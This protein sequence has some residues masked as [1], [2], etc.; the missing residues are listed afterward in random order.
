MFTGLIQ[1]VGQVTSA[2]CHT[3]GQG[4]PTGMV[5]TVAVDAGQTA[6]GDSFVSDDD[7]LAM[8]ESIT[9]NGVC[10]T[11][12]A[13]PTA[14]AFTVELSPETLAVT[15]LGELNTSALVNLERAMRP[16]DRFGGHIVSGHV[17]TLAQVVDRTDDG[18]CWRFYFRLQ[19]VASARYFIEK[20]SVTID[21]VSLTVNGLARDKGLFDVAII[22]HT[23]AHTTF[24]QLMP[25]MWV[26][27]ECDI[28]GKYAASLLAP[29]APQAD[30]QPLCD[31]PIA[32]AFA[33]ATMGNSNI[34]TG[35][36]FNL[37]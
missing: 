12:V 21:G 18:E 15:T 20:G 24:A 33:P 31:E 5:L 10:T 4:K 3:D 6:L 35:R 26:N 23:M 29:Y 22:P 37:G 16:N 7:P 32:E 27:I 34:H 19:D 11:V 36:W 13:L 28:I 17:D 1:T 25:D 8:G 14:Q 9:I 30:E 2:E